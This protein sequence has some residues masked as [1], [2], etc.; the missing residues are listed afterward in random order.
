[1]GECGRVVVCWKRERPLGC[2]DAAPA[3]ARRFV[4]QQLTHSLPA[5][6]DLAQMLSAAELVTSELATNAVRACR[7]VMAVRVEVHHRWVTLAVCD[8]G[9]GL[10]QLHHP[11]PLDVHGRGLQ[12]VTA[13]SAAWGSDPEPGGGK[14]VWCRLPLPAHA[15]D[16]LHCEQP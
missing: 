11:G 10:P 7:R 2:V 8:D 6:M 4:R 1:M 15:A 16:H 9:P 5:G 3:Q 12:I 14:T 13:L